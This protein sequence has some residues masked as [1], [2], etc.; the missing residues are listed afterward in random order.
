[1]RTRSGKLR[2]TAARVAV[3][4]RLN[5]GRW[6]LYSPISRVRTAGI[7]GSQAGPGAGRSGWRTAPALP[8]PPWPS[9]TAGRAEPDKF[10][11]LTEAAGHPARACGRPQSRRIPAHYVSHGAAFAITYRF[12]DTAGKTRRRRDLSPPAFLACS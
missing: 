1:M 7:A 10:V 12:G 9:I 5:D 11:V 8:V 4:S 2:C 3:S 6:I